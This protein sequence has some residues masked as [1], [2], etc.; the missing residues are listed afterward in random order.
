MLLIVLTNMR[1]ISSSYN[2]IYCGSNFPP[3]HFGSLSLTQEQRP[4]GVLDNVHGRISKHSFEQQT[5][6]AASHHNHIRLPHG[7][8][9]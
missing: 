5:A 4:V 2:G 1:G 8:Q 3:A 6:S 7:R 9:N